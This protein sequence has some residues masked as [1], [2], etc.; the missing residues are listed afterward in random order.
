L[1][2]WGDY[3]TH[4]SY[5]H[6]RGTVADMVL[7]AK[8]RGLKEVAITDHGPG[9]LFGVGIAHLGLVG[10]IKEEAKLWEDRTGI[11]VLVGL[12]ANVVDLDGRL[13]VDDRTIA[14]LDILIAGLHS[15]VRPGNWSS[16]WHFY[17]KVPIAR[18]LGSCKVR[19]LNTQALINAA[20]RHPVAFITHPGLHMDIDTYEL[21]TACHKC[22]TALE[23]NTSHNHTTLEYIRVAASTGVDFVISSDAHHPR[24]VGDF[25]KGVELAAGAGLSPERILNTRPSWEGKR[26]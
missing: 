16:L 4:T 14:Q 12:E 6:G 2:L 9:H 10:R 18:R 13:D 22:G 24:R 8:A 11:R 19:E 1:R 26:P 17:V 21:A 3:H 15:W 23:I 25:A 20:F 5:S 7:A